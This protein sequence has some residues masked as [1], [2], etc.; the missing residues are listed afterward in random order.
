MNNQE[1]QELMEI[2]YNKLSSKEFLDLGVLIADKEKEAQKEIIK[3]MIKN[4]EKYINID[5]MLLHYK[6]E[7]ENK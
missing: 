7:F 3:D 4:K 1:K 5:S 2:L 6:V